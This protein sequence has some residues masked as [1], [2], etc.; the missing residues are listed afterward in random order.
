MAGSRIWVVLLA[1]GCAPVWGQDATVRVADAPSETQGPPPRTARLTYVAEG[2]VKVATPDGASSVVAVQN[3]PLTEGMRL[4]A[5]ENGQAEVEF[6]DGSVVRMTPNSAI[7]LDQLGVDSEGK[8]KTVVSVM[9]GLVYAELRASSAGQFRVVA[10]FDTFWPLANCVV[11]VNMDEPPAVLSVLDGSVK[12]QHVS[13]LPSAPDPG[14]QS[15]NG[16]LATVRGGESIRSDMTDGT[17][18]FLSDRIAPESWDNWN[19]G[20]DQA[21]QD[22]LATATSVRDGYAGSE[23]YGWAD[24][25]A[26]GSWYDQGTGAPIWQPAEAQDAGFD[27]YG[28]GSWAYVT[29]VGYRWASGYRWGWTPFRCGRWAYYS[30]FG[31]AWQPDTYCGS[32]IGLGLAWGGGRMGGYG[33]HWPSGYRLPERPLVPIRS[34][35]K[36]HPILIKGPS[37]GAHPP[38]ERPRGPRHDPAPREIAGV[39]AK[40]IPYSGHPYTPRGGS[41]VGWGLK[42]DYAVDKKTNT[43]DLGTVSTPVTPVTLSSGPGWHAVTTRPDAP[44]SGGGGF[45]GFFHGNSKPQETPVVM[46][47][48]GNPV[49]PEV[50]REQNRQAE[51]HNDQRNT[52]ALPGSVPVRSN[53]IVAPAQPRNDAPRH[54]QNQA[55]RMENHQHSAP[56]ASSPA[57]MSH[58]APPSAAGPPA[59]HPHN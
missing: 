41:A 6:E 43:P 14:T 15:I 13:I 30:G 38:Y 59:C 34:P 47:R 49:V 56:A 54:D 31:W 58:S 7:S 51:F 18:Y 1:L 11:R 8:P 53:A 29:G 25:D 16:Y 20:R 46:D 32:R 26:N 42:R 24:L 36:I 12:V 2:V 37:D 57:P 17:R 35:G 45:H 44:A 21:A 55:P 48:R 3:M 28:Y 4:T 39:T 50:R 19:E 22:Q 27:P 9:G 33:D 40:P 23:G 10:Q 52:P 5:S